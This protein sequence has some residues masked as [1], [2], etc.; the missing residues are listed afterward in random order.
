VREVFSTSEAR[1]RDLI[2]NA[3]VLKRIDGENRFGR[4][5]WGLLS[6]ELWQRAFHDRAHEYRKRLTA[7]MEGVTL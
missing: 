4:Q 2:D 5:V 6:L 7:P 1:S 3:K